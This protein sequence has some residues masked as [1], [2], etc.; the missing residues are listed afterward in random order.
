MLTSFSSCLNSKDA[1]AFLKQTAGDVL[2]GRQLGNSSDPNYFE[3]PMYEDD[4][5][6]E[7]NPDVL[8]DVTDE[9]FLQ[10]LFNPVAAANGTVYTESNLTSVVVTSGYDNSTFGTGEDGN[11]YLF[12]NDEL[13]ES[14]GYQ[15]GVMPATEEDE[16][17]FYYTDAMENLGV[18]RMRYGNPEDVPVTADFLS[19]LAIN[20]DDDV[21]TPSLVLPVNTAGDAFWPV[22][23][24]YSDG[25]YSKFF[26]VRDLDAGIVTLESEEVRHIVTGGIVSQCQFWELQTWA[27]GIQF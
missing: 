9:E 15:D 2:K 21:S 24:D 20:N 22:L 27:V 25:Q 4:G 10:L 11:F 1:T 12:A 14:F 23:C 5:S 6:F 13:A 19:L 26:L 18:S 8:P 17:M 3:V 16:L 7:V